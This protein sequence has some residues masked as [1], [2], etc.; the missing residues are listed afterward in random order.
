[1]PDARLPPLLLALSAAAATVHA[2]SVLTR[3]TLILCALLPALPAQA[4]AAPTAASLSAEIR[5]IRDATATQWAG[6]MSDD[7]DF[8]NPF[9]ADLA[10]GHGSFAPP[11]LSYSVHRAGHAAAAERA[12]PKSVDPV[13]ASA[14]D[15]VGAAYALRLAPL[16][17]ERRAQLTDYVSRY[18]IPTNGHRC[19]TRPRCWSN[20]KLVDA[21][22]VLAITGAGVASPDPA[23]RLHDPVAARAAAAQVVNEHVPRAVD[24]GLRG[25]AAGRRLQGTVLSDPPADPLAYHVLSTFI[26][27]EAI[28]ELGPATGS[29]TRRAGRRTLD[30]L[31]ALVAPDGDASYLGRGQDQVWVPA[32]TAA[33]LAN[34]AR[35]AAATDPRRAGRYLAGARAAIRRLAARHA[36]PQ[37]L[38]LV[39]GE[40]TTTAGIDSYAHTVAYNGLAMFGLTAALDALAAIPDARIGK[41]PAARRLA[42]E[43]EDASGL[44]VAATGRAWIAVHRTATNANDLRHDAGALALKLRTRRRGWVDLLAPRPLTLTSSETAAPA[45]IRRGR[46]LR[47]DGFEIYARRNMVFHRAGYRNARGKIVR[48][49]H[50]HW[51]LT[52]HGARFTLSGARRGDRFRMLAFTPAG[53]GSGRRKALFANGARWR[54]SRPVRVARRTGYHSGPVEN[55]DALEVLASAPKSGRIVVRIGL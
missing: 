14:F 40:R 9:P 8:V 43:D 36:S 3:L 46:A 34:G 52:R 16:S 25:R 2:A 22:A 37:G 30:A 27:S 32:L 54:F 45:L 44:A 12:W 29:R 20:L 55:L 21:L 1:L 18:G 42:F 15:M 6:M 39:G 49:I 31:A 28:V 7:G 47:P 24:N 23:A 51:R 4:E 19:L 35:G 38:K 41:L 48:R 13:R 50:M 5:A 33:A 11:M 17:D 53:T 26:L 10:R